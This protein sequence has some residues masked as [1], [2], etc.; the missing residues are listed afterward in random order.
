MKRLMLATLMFPVFAQANSVRSSVADETKRISGI[1]KKLSEDVCAQDKPYARTAPCMNLQKQST[2]VEDDP[3]AP[4]EF[5]ESVDQSKVTAQ[6]YCTG[7]QAGNQRT[8][9]A[10]GIFSNEFDVSI[11]VTY[12][13][14]GED[15]STRIPAGFDVY[16][17]RMGIGMPYVEEGV[18]YPADEYPGPQY[19]KRVYGIDFEGRGKE[20]NLQIVDSP[21]REEFVEKGKKLNER[22]L[23]TDMRLTG[24]NFFPRLVV[25]SVRVRE[26]KISLKLGT[27]EN[28][29]VEASTGRVIGGVAKEVPAKKMIEKRLD[30][31]GNGNVRTFPDTDFIYTGDAIWIETK[32]TD[33]LDEKKPGNLVTARANVDGKVQECKLKSENI[34]V[35]NWGYYLPQGHDRYLSS[36]WQ[37]VKFKFETDQELFTMIKKTCPT[38]KFPAL[39]K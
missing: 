5:S 39:A 17:E 29:E 20:S 4:W 19:P 38:F 37:C 21:V 33:S 7:G 28:I 25:P 36:G 16:A 14:Q 11:N 32:V 10:N 34:W 6:D 27:G 35:R 3:K 15:K 23:S 31:L 24:Y 8:K 13:Q 12:Q 30:K 22:F 26:G 2:P 18:E 9:Y 1:A